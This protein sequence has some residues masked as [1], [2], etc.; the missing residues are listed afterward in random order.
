MIFCSESL[1]DTRTHS[2]ETSNGINQQET[3][4]I[5]DRG[6]ENEGIAVRGSFSYTDPATNQ[7]YTVTYIAVSYLNLQIDNISVLFLTH[8]EYSAINLTTDWFFEPSL[9]RTRTDSSH[10]LPIFQSAQ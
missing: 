4:E 9:N 8:S 3:G 6:T 5:V 1:A 10:P 2:S 7:V